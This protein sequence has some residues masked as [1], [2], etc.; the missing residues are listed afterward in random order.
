M[1][2]QLPGEF[3]KRPLTFLFLLYARGVLGVG[4]V[5][6][7]PVNNDPPFLEVVPMAIETGA[8]EPAVVVVSV[9]NS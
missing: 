6:Y 7:L 9:M 5:V 4:S 8:I 1:R 2:I 3:L